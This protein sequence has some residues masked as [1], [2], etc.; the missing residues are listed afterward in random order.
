MKKTI[1]KEIKIIETIEKI[2]DS[3]FTILDFIETFKKLFPKKWSELVNRFGLFGK[4]KRY[5]VATYL[6]NRLYSY[7]QKE[8]S[9]L[10]TFQ[11]YKKG[12]KGNYRKTTKEEKKY[13]GS[14]W[15]AIYNKK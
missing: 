14:P 9:L 6:S 3:S 13:F 10:K 11:K 1:L 15:I 4:K 8:N 12:D 2:Q 5:T 7:S